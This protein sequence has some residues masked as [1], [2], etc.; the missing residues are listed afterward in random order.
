MRST[1]AP[2][3]IVTGGIS[4]LVGELPPLLHADNTPASA[5]AT[6]RRRVEAA[7]IRSR[8]DSSKNLVAR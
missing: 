1:C 6:A 3:G 4:G 7:M 8:D 2:V 5:S